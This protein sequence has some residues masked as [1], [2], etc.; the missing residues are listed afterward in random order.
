MA[1]SDERKAELI[2]KYRDI[3]INY[4][5]WDAAYDD[6][7]SI[8]TILGIDL[9]KNEPSFSGFWSQG[10]GASFTG[11]FSPRDILD[12]PAKMREHAPKDEELHRIADELCE[13]NIIYL[14]KFWGS[15]RRDDTRYCH[16]NTMVG[17][18]AT[19]NEE[20]DYWPDEVF[21]IVDASFQQLMRDLADW[22]YEVLEKEYDWRTSDE[23]VW[24]AIVANELDEEEEEEEDEEDEDA[25]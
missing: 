13:L 18:I 22:L 9:D 11:S 10:D 25:A 12:A 23:E 19:L 4:E 14:T 8:C 21:G 2:E 16:S 5:W 20:P 17:E 6:F 7:K 24:E 3:N 15:I 1:I